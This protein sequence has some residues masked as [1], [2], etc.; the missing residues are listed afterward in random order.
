M[1]FMNS[2]YDAFLGCREIKEEKK[3]R[4]CCRHGGVGICVHDFG[5]E[6]CWK[7]TNW[8]S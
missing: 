3:D 6:V 4:A 2:T 8:N 1:N 5:G 7:E